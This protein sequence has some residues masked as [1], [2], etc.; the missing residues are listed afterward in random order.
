[1]SELISEIFV[2][3]F[4]KQLVLM[5]R[6]KAKVVNSTCQ[7]LHGCKNMGVLCVLYMPERRG[8]TAPTSAPKIAVF[9]T[10]A[11]K[12]DCSH[13]QTRLQSKIKGTVDSCLFLTVIRDGHPCTLF[14]N[15]QGT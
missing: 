3:A 6:S 12:R 14:Q 15:V 13:C 8:R 4:L 1:M 2:S 11:A 10:F 9:N 7:S 5:T